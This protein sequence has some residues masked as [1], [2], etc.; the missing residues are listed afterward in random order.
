LNIIYNA[1]KFTREG[2]FD[3]ILDFSKSPE[4]QSEGC[5]ELLTT[6]KDTGIGMDE[7]IKKNLF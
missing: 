6:V 2:G 4:C 7:E 1:V 5:G 3:V